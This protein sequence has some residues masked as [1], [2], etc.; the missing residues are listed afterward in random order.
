M[1]WSVPRKLVFVDDFLQFCF[2]AEKQRQISGQ[3]GV[4]DLSQNLG[5]A[6]WL[7]EDIEDWIGGRMNG[8]V[9]QW[10]NKWD[11]WMSGWVGGCMGGWING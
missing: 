10:I 11:W 9:D 1:F 7:N 4:S 2:V 8:W 5:E 3:D 6:S